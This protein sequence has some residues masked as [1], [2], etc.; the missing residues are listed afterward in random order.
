MQP[1]AAPNRLS[2]HGETSA[3]TVVLIGASI[4]AA[5]QSANRAGFRVLGIDHFGDVDT[6]Q[7]CQEFWILNEFQMNPE[8]IRRLRNFPYFVVGGLNPAHNLAGLLM[9]PSETAMTFPAKNLDNGLAVTPQKTNGDR[10]NDPHWLGNLSKECGLS[11]PG[12][13]HSLLP[14]AKPPQTSG[15]RWLL[16]TK[17]SCGGLGVR[18]YTPPPSGSVPL[19]AELTRSNTGTPNPKIVPSSE[20]LTQHETKE[21]RDPVFQEWVPGRPHG[22]T[23]L[24]NG[25]ECCLLGVCR[26]LF[27]HIGDLPFVYRGSFGPVSIPDTLQQRLQKLGLRITRE[28]GHRGLLNIDLVINRSGKTFV[29]EVNPRWSGSSELIERWMCD[30]IRTRSLFGTMIDACN[31]APMPDLK[32]DSDQ[33]SKSVGSPWSEGPQYLKRIIFARQPFRFSQ[34]LLAFSTKPANDIRYRSAF[35]DLPADGTWISAGEP[36]C[37]LV[38]QIPRRT[39][40]KSFCLDKEKG[41]LHQ[42]RTFLRHLFESAHS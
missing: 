24:C 2:N 40:D 29:L 41:P 21:T 33:P 10:W 31:G 30:Q 39:A 32:P 26:S 5:A 28:T 4:R 38:S 12:I 9:P 16:K 42:H 36:I 23:L 35:S 11:F 20:S 3:G 34:D 14:N 22:A 6:R 8:L 13:F 18:W 37:T 7:A 19:A 25:T 17:H 1:P 27:T 15:K